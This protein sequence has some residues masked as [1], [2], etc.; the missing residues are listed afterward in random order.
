MDIKRSG[1]QGTLAALRVQ[2]LYSNYKKMGT[3][4][5]CV[6]CEGKSYRGTIAEV[7]SFLKG[8]YPTADYTVPF[9]GRI[10][11]SLLQRHTVILTDVNTH[12]LPTTYCIR[13]DKFYYTV[14]YICNGLNQFC[15]M[16][17]NKKLCN[18][19]KERITKRI[20]AGDYDEQGSDCFTLITLPKVL[21]IRDSA[22]CNENLYRDQLYITVNICG[23]YTFC[24]SEQN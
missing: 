7:T 19:D 8:L 22:R 9:K 11:M 12:I 24:I 1:L 10:N 4:D 16:V 20:R 15:L 13:P 17:V 5:V 21:G 18:E 3:D 14:R 2:G 23:E 6:S